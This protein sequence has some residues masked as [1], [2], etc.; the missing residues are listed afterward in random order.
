M[1]RDADASVRSDG[2]QVVGTQCSPVFT[3]FN[4]CALELSQLLESS[5]FRL[6]LKTSLSSS[7]LRHLCATVLAIAQSMM[8]K[9]HL[10]FLTLHCA[11]TTNWHDCNQ[12]IVMLTIRPSQTCISYSSVSLA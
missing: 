7:R 5:S 11:L 2:S 1:E 12:I 6:E 9:L 3:I 10:D 4:V 8:W